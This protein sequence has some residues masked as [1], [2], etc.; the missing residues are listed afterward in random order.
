MVDP[1]YNNYI[2]ICRKRDLLSPEREIELS[3]RILDARQRGEKDSEACNELVEHHIALV[4]K[5]VRKKRKGLSQET[6]NDLVQSATLALLE[7]AAPK[8]DYRKG[9]RFSTYAYWWV[10]SALAASKEDELAVRIPRIVHGRKR[11]PISV[12][13]LEDPLIPNA[14]MVDAR[15]YGESIADLSFL[16]PEQNMEARQELESRNAK[17]RILIN[18]IEK[19]LSTVSDPQKKMFELRYGLG[20]SE[21]HTLGE[22]AAEVGLSAERV[23]QVTERIRSKIIGVSPRRCKGKTLSLIPRD[24]I[25]ELIELIAAR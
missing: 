2:A 21:E 15:T 13:S 11:V 19:V 17:R 23:R 24:G 7:H 12:M 8:F 25:E 14:E 4:C 22:I 5:I 18:N 1:I 20:G 9:G 10:L 6:F 16:N 3:K